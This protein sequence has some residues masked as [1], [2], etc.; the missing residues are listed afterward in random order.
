MKPQGRAMM[1]FPA[2]YHTI[3]EHFESSQDPLHY[4]LTFRDA[5][6]TRRDIYRFFKAIRAEADLQNSYGIKLMNIA[7]SLSLSI[8]PNK[9]EPDDKT[10]FTVRF[11]S[12][13]SQVKLVEKPSKGKPEAEVYQD[14]I[15]LEGIE[16]LVKEFEK[17]EEE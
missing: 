6:S 12:F 4:E 1:D 11:N 9:G 8:V 15:N 14:T 13:L 7:N 2:Q 5:Q 10:I 3:L 17:G 16:D